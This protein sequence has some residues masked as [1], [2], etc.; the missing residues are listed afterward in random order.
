M[1][2]IHG[3]ALLDIN[4]QCDLF[5]TDGSYPLRLTSAFPSAVTRLFTWFGGMHFPVISTRLRTVA[6]LD[7]SHNK[8]VCDPTSHGYEKLSCTVLPNHLELPADCGTDLPAEAFA[9]AQQYIFDLPDANPFDSPRLDR[10]LSETEA[11]IWLVVG[12]PLESSLRMAV[13]G[14]LQRRQKVAIVKECVGQ[15]DAYEG[16]MTLRQLESK[17]ID[18][19]T[20]EETISRFSPKSRVVRNGTVT[21]TRR[22]RRVQLLPPYRSDGRPSRTAPRFR[23]SGP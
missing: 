3:P 7:P 15:K 1:T 17:N 12:G 4:T 21:R 19:L 10:L 20:V 14:L 22:S 5:E 8:A 23:V 11:G 6:H 13:L 9:S 2:A 18:W 16:E